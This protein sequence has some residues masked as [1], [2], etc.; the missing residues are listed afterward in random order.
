MG[1]DTLD[2]VVTHKLGEGLPP[3]T[4]LPWA[5]GGL[6]RALASSLLMPRPD[7]TLEA[8]TSGMEW[9]SPDGSVKIKTVALGPCGQGPRLTGHLVSTVVTQAAVTNPPLLSCVGLDAPLPIMQKIA[10]A[11][12]SVE[13]RLTSR[14]PSSTPDLAGRPR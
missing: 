2:Q 6:G 7:L 8:L 11:G 12:G 10:W 9:N 5:Q 1:G 13:F 4:S 3:I 14:T